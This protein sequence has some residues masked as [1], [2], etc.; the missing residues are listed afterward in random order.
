M[1]YILI[2]SILL[3]CT[4]IYTNVHMSCIDFALASYTIAFLL[5]RYVLVVL[6]L[7]KRLRGIVVCLFVSN[8][9]PFVSNQRQSY[10]GLRYDSS[11]S[12]FL[13]FFLV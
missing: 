4:N 13:L 7:V 12:L 3:T 9:I 10:I 11:L 8:C 1:L 5:P 6:R 2:C